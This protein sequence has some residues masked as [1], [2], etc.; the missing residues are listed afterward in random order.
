VGRE[1]AAVSAATEVSSRWQVV[2]FDAVLWKD[3]C[4]PAGLLDLA[5]AWRH[6]GGL[7]ALRRAVDRARSGAQTPLETISRLSLLEEGLP[8]PELQVAFHDAEGLIGYVDMWWPDPRGIGEAD[9]AL[10]YRSPDDL[11]T[12]KVREDRLRALGVIVV[13]RTWD[14]IRTNPTAVAERIRRA[15]RRA[16]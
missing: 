2:L 3:G 8:E 13:R 11:M 1:L 5:E 6:L 4:L 10:K 15:A 9:G 12:E 16:A 14:E 7:D